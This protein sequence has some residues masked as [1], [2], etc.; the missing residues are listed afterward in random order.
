MFR[1]CLAAVLTLGG[2][3][4]VAPAQFYTS[5]YA[6]SY[7]GYY[8]SPPLAYS[9]YSTTRAYG[10]WSVFDW[11]RW[12]GVSPYTTA[13][14]PSYSAGYSPFGYSAGY[15]PVADTTLAFYAP[16][17]A[18]SG[19]CC[20]S[21]CSSCSPCVACAGGNCPGGNC[22]LNYGP[23]DMSPQPDPATSGSSGTSGTRTF[24]SES[25]GAAEPAADDNR[26][27]NNERYER[28]PPP[29]DGF[30]PAGRGAGYRPESTI[31]QKAPTRVDEPAV[32][33]AGQTEPL[34]DLPPQALDGSGT[35]QEFE[36]PAGN[37]DAAAPLLDLDAQLT[38][39]PSFLPV[40]RELRAQFGSPALARATVDPATLPAATDLHLVRK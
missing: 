23:V 34:E 37:P 12:A 28:Q 31:Q 19:A 18:S 17:I 10:P 38:Q 1:L 25:E 15:A 27:D 11:R 4:S 2:L 20:T 32:A 33:P 21:C 5:Y 8:H 39:A 29:E 16:A 36:R 35:E 26:F 14:A 30:N 40:R 7:S 3:A 24:R 13:Y 9:S 22:G 6:P